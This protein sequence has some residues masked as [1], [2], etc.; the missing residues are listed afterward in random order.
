[1]V[2]KLIWPKPEPAIKPEPV[3][4]VENTAVCAGT[5]SATIDPSDTLYIGHCGVAVPTRMLPGG[6][7]IT[8]PCPTSVC[9]P[10][11]LKNH[12]HK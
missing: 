1:L 9:S 12:L 7:S 10:K 5:S 6:I 11:L 2:L 8:F 4:A 3:P